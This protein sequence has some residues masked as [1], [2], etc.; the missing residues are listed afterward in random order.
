MQFPPSLFRAACLL[1]IAAAVG[2]AGC[3][4]GGGAGSEST[5]G[6]AASQAV[7]V[8]NFA[9]KPADVTVAKG[10]TVEFTNEDS[11]SHTATSSSSGAFDTGTIKPGKTGSITLDEAGTFTYFCSFHPFMKGTITVE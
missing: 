2:I 9:F 4:G 11:T 6:G 7:T 3:G 8:Q 5:G 1:T 10:T